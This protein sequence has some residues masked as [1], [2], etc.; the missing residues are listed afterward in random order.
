MKVD[1]PKGGEPVLVMEREF[2]APRDLVWA[3]EWRAPSCWY[4]YPTFA[5]PNEP[6]AA[7]A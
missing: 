4:R 7:A 3:A 5:A 1:V 6:C 2:S